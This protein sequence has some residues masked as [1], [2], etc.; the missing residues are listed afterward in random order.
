MLTDET[1]FQL[2]NMGNQR[3][4]KWNYEILDQNGSDLLSSLIIPRSSGMYSAG[5]INKEDDTKAFL[6]MFSGRMI[7]DT[8]Y[9]KLERRD[10][11][12]IKHIKLVYSRPNIDNTS[13]RFVISLL[14]NLN[15]WIEVLKFDNNESLTDDYIWGFEEIDINFKNYGI[16]LKYDNIKSNKQDMAISRIILTYAV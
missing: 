1:L 5:L 13:C 14:N 11:H 9:V 4:T 3:N 12:N 2:R 6:L 15:E 8:P 7:S 16:I 10:I